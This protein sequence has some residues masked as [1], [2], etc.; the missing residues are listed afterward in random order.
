VLL[1]PARNNGEKSITLLFRAG[2]RIVSRPNIILVSKKRFA[3]IY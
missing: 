3:L 2:F 1:K